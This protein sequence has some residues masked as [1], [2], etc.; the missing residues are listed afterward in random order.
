VEDQRSLEGRT[1]TLGENVANVFTTGIHGKC[2][3]SEMEKPR[4]L[5]GRGGLVMWKMLSGGRA[6]CS[7]RKSCDFRMEELKVQGG[8]VTIPW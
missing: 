6:A 4:A 1:K 7:L 8:R 3:D 5:I 2:C